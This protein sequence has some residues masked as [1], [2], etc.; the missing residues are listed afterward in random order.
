MKSPV[1]KFILTVSLAVSLCSVI[2]AASP[3]GR[4]Y[5]NARPHGQ[6]TL[7]EVRAW[8]QKTGPIKGFNEPAGG[9]P[10]M[11]DEDI[12]RRTS[13]LGFNS[14]RVWV[15]GGTAGEQISYLKNILDLAGKYG[16]TVSPVLSLHRTAEYFGN[17]DREKGIRNAEVMIKQILEPFKDDSRIAFWDLWNEPNCDIFAVDGGV[18]ESGTRRELEFI[19]MMVPWC[20]EA[21]LTQPISASIF[22]DS[23][24][25]ADVTSDLFE[26]KAKVE[27]MMDLHNFHSYA[28]SNDSR[29]I[30]Y[31]IAKL[32]KMS[33]RPLVC[34]E[35]LTRTNGSGIGRS[36]TKFADEHVHFYVWGSFISDR[37]WT[38]KWLRSTYN[39]YDVS[40]HNTMYA[41]GDLMDGREIDMV[42]NFKF[43]Q[44]GEPSADPGIEYTERWSHERAWKRMVGGPVKGYCIDGFDAAGVP[45]HYGSVRVRVRYSDWAQSEPDE[46]FSEADKIVSSLSS[47]GLS[48]LPVLLDDSDSG[49]RSEKLAEYVSAVVRHFYTEPAIVAW[50][51]YYHPGEKCTDRGLVEDILTKAFRA[52]RNVY[53]NQP[54]TATPCVRVKSFDEG[55]DYENA[56]MHGRT[57]GWDR[58]EYQGCSDASLVHKIWSVSDVVSFSTDQPQGE[59]G[60]LLSICFR[61]GRPIFCT[62]MDSPSEEEAV[63]TLDRFAMSHVFWF[64]NRDINAETVRSFKFIPIMTEY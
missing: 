24:C 47:R 26:Y 41:D 21:G 34:T 16:M 45:G 28:C 52:A 9:W 43:T 39:P 44:P 51:L 35:C 8:E 5:S 58:L 36:L 15:R 62:D 3:N 63:K 30:D 17:P 20:W 22:F 53:P 25:S 12:L 42:R 50:D 54:L 31:T 64:S 1:L 57:G 13:E 29:D 10:G 61:Y 60:W 11:T 27:G 38:V 32:R 23:E 59:A 2:S 19:E 49:V 33:D 6:W 55:F 37:N 48:I 46:F 40:F 14:V 4:K 18:T 7:D 56:L